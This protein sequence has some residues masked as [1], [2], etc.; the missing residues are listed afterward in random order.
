[1]I[2]PD[3][4]A[5]SMRCAANRP[6]GT[7]RHFNLD[8]GQQLVQ[9]T[10]FVQD[11]IHGSLSDTPYLPEWLDKASGYGICNL[12]GSDTLLHAIHPGTCTVAQAKSWSKDAEAVSWRGGEGD[13]MACPMWEER[14]TSAGKGS[15]RR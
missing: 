15:R 14:Q 1:M 9:K 4:Q 10:N 5:N 13:I 6:H 7:C 12:I 2:V 11:L 8:A 3:S